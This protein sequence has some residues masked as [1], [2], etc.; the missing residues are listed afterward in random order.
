MDSETE[1][2]SVEE[3]HKKLIDFLGK[4]KLEWE[5]NLLKYSK[6][7]FYITYEEVERDKQHNVTLRQEATT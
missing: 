3:L 2:N 5:E 6:D 4:N 1:I 7:N